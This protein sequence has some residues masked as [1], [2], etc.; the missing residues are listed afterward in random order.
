MSKLFYIILCSI[1]QSPKYSRLNLSKTINARLEYLNGS[2]G[3]FDRLQKHNFFFSTDGWRSGKKSEYNVE[4]EVQS[5]SRCPDYWL[6]I[7]VYLLFVSIPLPMY[8]ILLPAG[9]QSTSYVPSFT[10]C[11]CPGHWICIQSY[12]LQVPRPLAEYSLLLSVGT[13]ITS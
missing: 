3:P 8:P 13:E 7:Q 10:Y 4:N 11:R 6:Y 12:L 1:L 9:V 5:H 2:T